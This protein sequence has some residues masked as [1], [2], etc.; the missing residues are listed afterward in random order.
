[1]TALIV[2][3][4]RPTPFR[5]FKISRGE[6]E[7]PATRVRIDAR[8]GIF[9]LVLAKAVVTRVSEFVELTERARRIS[10]RRRFENFIER[11]RAH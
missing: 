5:G 2:P 9:Y 1:M 10:L 11:S 4:R 7:V 3:G 8:G 6:K